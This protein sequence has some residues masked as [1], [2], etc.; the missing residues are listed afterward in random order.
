ML[1]P[2]I[3]IP[4]ANNIF[5]HSNKGQKRNKMKIRLVPWFLLSLL[6]TSCSINNGDIKQITISKI[7]TMPNMPQPYKML[8]WHKMSVN[9]DRV[10]F[11][12]NAKGKYSP[13]IWLDN[14]RRNID[15]ETFGI[16]TAIGDIRQGT[17]HHNGE[18]HE[19]LTS[20]G[21]LMSAGLVGINK[22]DQNGYNYVKMVQNYFNTDNDWNIIL[23]TTNPEVVGRGF[24]HDWWYEVFLNVSYYAVSDLFPDVDGSDRILKSIAK[25]F[26]QADSV[27][28]GDYDY[29]WFNYA[30]M[31]GMR[32]DIPYEQDAA[33]GH[34]YVLYEAYKKF[35]DTRYLNGAKSAIKA[36]L[37]QKESRFYEVL[38]PFGAYVAARLNAEQGTN[39]DITKIIN[40]TFDGVTASD[41]RTGWGVI[42][43]RWG[44]YDISGL[45]GSA[46]AGG[47]Y[48]FLMNT[49]VLAWP[50]VSMVRYDPR[51]ARAIGKWMLN[52]ANA[53][54][55]FYP[56]EIPDSNQWLPEKKAITRHVI[57][58]EGLRKTD[59]YY[60]KERLKGVSPVALGDGPR[61]AKGE[62]DVSMFSIYGSAYVGIFGSI[63]KKTNVKEILQLNCLA[64]DFYKDVAYPTYLYFNPYDKMKTIEYTPKSG[65]VDLY[66]MISGKVI[67]REIKGKGQFSIAGNS[68]RVTVEIPSGTKIIRSHGKVTA[69]GIVISYY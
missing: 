25:K 65:T 21:A 31:K 17:D 24:E 34:A 16:Y 33:A 1:I 19:A 39:Y 57:A 67:A 18:Y 26:Y 32:N 27:L 7:E 62:P 46:T 10:V 9:F 29:S 41:G 56:Y 22:K 5:K 30:T 47:G 55:L 50:M 4:V 8:D 64:T 38:M 54:R 59:A 48:G 63:I 28:N 23:N 40:W 11:N 12:F 36:L 66:D 43:G 69:N 44:N 53:A 13:F 6:L 14:A 35:G 45:V 51:Y 20:L 2:I 58:Y 68:A 52:A 37:N 60:H 15:Q 42:A 61:W 3:V 49:F